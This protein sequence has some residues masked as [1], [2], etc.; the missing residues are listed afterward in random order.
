MCDSNLCVN[1][2]GIY[3]WVP[4][5]VT[6]KQHQEGELLGVYGES[7]RV[8]LFGPGMCSCVRR[9][10]HPLVVAIMGAEPSS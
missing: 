9:G 6:S 1:F 10:C 8:L 2:W 5:V 7:L 4:L 3:E